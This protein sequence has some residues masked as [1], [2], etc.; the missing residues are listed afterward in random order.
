MKRLTALLFAALAATQI[1]LAQHSVLEEVRKLSEALTA[2]KNLNSVRGIEREILRRE[3]VGQKPGFLSA[4][5]EFYRARAYPDDTFDWEEYNR[6]GEYRDAMEPAEP[7]VQV[8]F[9]L[10]PQLSPTGFWSFVGP[11]NTAPSQQQYF[12]DRAIMGRVTA[13]ALPPNPRGTLARSRV[14]YAATPGGGIWRTTDSGE[15]WEPLTDKSNNWPYLQV[16]AICVTNP[17]T[18]DPQTAGDIVIAGTGDPRGFFRLYS[19]GVIRSLDGGRTWQTPIG[20]APFSPPV[21]SIVVDPDEP[22][23][24]TLTTGGAPVPNTGVAN[25]DPATRMNYDGRIYQSTD[26]GATWRQ[27]WATNAYWGRVSIGAKRRDGTR[28]YWAV[29]WD[30]THAYVKR[31]NN[32]G[33]TW[34]DATA[35]PGG[36]ATG[37]HREA[38]LDIAASKNA[39]DTAYLMSGQDK[40][41]WQT[42]NRGG[43]WTRISDNLIVNYDGAG[44]NNWQQVNYDYHLE[45]IPIPGGGSD[46]V[47]VGLLTASAGRFN[48]TTNAWDWVDFART[49]RADA[50]AHND[51][52]CIVYDQQDPKRFFIGHD[53]GIHQVV[54]D[55][56]AAFDQ[57]AF[58][59]TNRSANLGITQF[60]DGAWHPHEADQMLGGTQDN[61][62]PRSSGAG[63]ANMNNW[64]GAAWGDGSGSEINPINPLIQLTTGNLVSA[65]LTDD[66]WVTFNR[67]NITINGGRSHYPPTAMDYEGFYYRGDGF[68]NRHQTDGRTLNPATQSSLSEFATNYVT[69]LATAPADPHRIYAGTNTGNVWMCLN[70]HGSPMPFTRSDRR[71]DGSALA[72]GSPPLRYVTDIVVDPFNP[73][74]IVVTYS[75]IGTSATPVTDHVYRCDDTQAAD[76]TRSFV[77]VDSGAHKLPNLPINSVTWDYGPNDASAKGTDFREEP[78][79][80][81]NPNGLRRTIR[82]NDDTFDQ[83]S[84][85][86]VVLVIAGT[87]NGD[88]Q[89]TLTHAGKT[90]ILINGAGRDG[91]LDPGYPDDGYSIVLTDQP[92]NHLVR[93]DIHLY[94]QV[95]GPLPVGSPVTGYWNS[96]GRDAA[97][98]NVT[99]ATPRT[100]RLDQFNAGPPNG[101]W[102]LKISDNGPG[103]QHRLLRW[104]LVVQGPARNGGDNRRVF[105]AGDAGVFMTLDIGRNPVEWRNMTQPLGL[106]PV[107]V[108]DIEHIPGT[109]KLNIATF[110]RGMWRVDTGTAVIPSAMCR[111][112]RFR[113]GGGRTTELRVNLA[114]PAPAG[115]ATVRVTSNDAKLTVP[116]TGELVIP[117]GKVTGTM[118]LTSPGAVPGAPI[119]VRISVEYGREVRHTNVRLTP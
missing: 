72:R 98:G 60:Y 77:N 80:D 57:N 104:G 52:H 28:T 118:T 73:D 68:V 97:I 89:A 115:G 5:L 33:A 53:G 94:R 71:A 75:G 59:M 23:R 39:P 85:V 76:A 25:A 61:M 50:K 10:G 63:A 43:A 65:F 22:G 95:T 19:T 6:G 86:S 3:L 116:G 78:I 99:F 66:G 67:R 8:P 32:R 4:L 38:S 36:I 110:G 16:G 55:R 17:D 114:R 64:V 87:F 47:I 11:R 91:L 56:A 103:D 51:Q 29:G 40:R 42:T 107:Q 112:T 7:L 24:I 44:G 83:V 1:G 58:A 100:K 18:K 108:N 41:V 26:F 84:G 37:N 27:I 34:D 74:R 48:A 113:G 14:L 119:D 49:G 79:P 70:T 12:G 69:A 62:S 2:P 31:S 109:G 35:P 117:E 88:I 21:T 54:W 101:D 81:N 90:A 102:E 13:L 93:G 20:S 30:A 82:I 92:G 111:P 9:D 96:D 46:L 106:P 45:A 105:V 15:T